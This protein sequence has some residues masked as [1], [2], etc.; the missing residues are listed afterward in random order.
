MCMNYREVVCN[1]ML[2]SLIHISHTMNAEIFRNTQYSYEISAESK[3]RYSCYKTHYIMIGKIWCGMKVNWVSDGG[4]DLRHHKCYSYYSNW[5]DT[6]KI[7]V[8]ISSIF[9]T[10]PMYSTF[11]HIE[12]FLKHKKLFTFYQKKSDFK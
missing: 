11:Q 5:C 10:K 3:G 4:M 9:D 7:K 12:F 6:P 1:K 8:Y 2:N